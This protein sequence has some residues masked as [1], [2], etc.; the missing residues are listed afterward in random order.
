MPSPRSSRE[1]I[2]TA[3][4]PLPITPAGTLLRCSEK[5]LEWWSNVDD[6]PN[7]NRGRC[8]C[9]ESFAIELDWHYVGAYVTSSGQMRQN[10]CFT[11]SHGEI[12]VFCTSNRLAERTLPPGFDAWQGVIGDAFEQHHQALASLELD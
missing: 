11:V 2:A 1:Y 7:L 6:P 8:W 4:A 12:P 3:S 5:S 10:N 9:G